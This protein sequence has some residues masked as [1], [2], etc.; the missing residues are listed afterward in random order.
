MSES[1]LLEKSKNFAVDVIR[2]SKSIRETQ[3][4]FVL[5][6]Q[7][8]RAGTS[9]GANIHESKYAHSTMDF[10]SKMQI[11][12]KECYETEYWLEML[13]RTDYIPDVQYRA[14]LHT[15]GE[16][17]RMLIAS[18]NTTKEHVPTKATKSISK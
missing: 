4:E 6:N 5:T 9:I 10:I 17:R 3:H 15:C 18:I 1:I 12:L 2:I 11:A 14:L 13:F 7:M 8:L 16:L